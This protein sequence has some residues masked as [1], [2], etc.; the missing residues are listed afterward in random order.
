MLRS[1]PYGET[2]RFIRGAQGIAKFMPGTAR[3]RGLEDSFDPGQAI[4][5]SAELLRDL[6]REFGNLGLAAA[7]YNAGSGREHDWLVGRKPLPRETD[8]RLVTGRSAEEWAGRG[9]EL[10]LTCELE[11]LE[12]KFAVAPSGDTV[13]IAAGTITPTCSIQPAAWWVRQSGSPRRSPTA[14]SERWTS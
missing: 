1:L 7:A 11:R 9:D 2:E 3:Q 10:S 12:A 8:V 13:S 5:K 4:P 6:N 14:S